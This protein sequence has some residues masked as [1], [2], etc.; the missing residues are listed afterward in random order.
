MP[1]EEA[2][3]ETLAHYIPQDSV[4]DVMQYLKHYKVHLTITRKRISVLGDYRH[5]IP[6]KNHRISVNGNLNPYSFLV[7][8]L[9]ELAHLVAFE[10]FRNRIPSHGREWKKEYADILAHFINKKIFPGDIEAA[11]M[12]SLHDAA[13]SSCGD[14][15]LLRALKKYD[16]PNPAAVSVEQVGEQALFSTADGRVFRKGR[17]L[18]TRF[19][20]QEVGT[21]KWFLFNALYE[22]S[23][24]ADEK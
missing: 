17:K 6:G 10:K 14:E 20:C 9:H 12:A 15:K 11:L 16:R 5:P 3:L 19:K 13:A 1:K 24:V 22:V 7:T 4:D 21:G 8:L 2:P 18:R 23:M